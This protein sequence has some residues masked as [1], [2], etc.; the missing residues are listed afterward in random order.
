MAPRRLRRTG[1]TLIELLVAMSII[2]IL[3]GLVAAGIMSWIGSQQRRN[4]EATLAALSQAIQKHWDAV[5]AEAKKDQVPKIVVD[6]S[7]PT[8]TGSPDPELARIIWI[9]LRLME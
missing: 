3:G 1:V 2:A 4:T 8:P 6:L 9:K 7:K 5:V